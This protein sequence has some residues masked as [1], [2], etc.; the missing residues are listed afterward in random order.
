MSLTGKNSN[1]VK[2]LIP[3]DNHMCTFFSKYG[4]KNGQAETRQADRQT[5]RQ[6]EKQTNSQINK[7]SEASLQSPHLVNKKQKQGNYSANRLA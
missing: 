2:L 6:T 5:E 4:L 7:S 3:Y 1:D